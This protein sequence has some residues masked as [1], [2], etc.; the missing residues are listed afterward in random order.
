MKTII[1]PTGQCSQLYLDISKQTHVLVAGTTGSG[2]SVVTRGIL[3]ALLYRASGVSADRAELIL[4]DPKGTE[5]VEYKYAP[6]CIS[7][8]SASND[9]S[10]LGV[11]Q[12]ASDLVDRRFATMQKDPSKMDNRHYYIGS[13]VWVVIDELADLMLSPDASVVK[14]LIQHIGQLGRAARVHLLCC[15]Q[16]PIVK[17]IPTEIKV[18][19]DTILALRT[20]SAQDSRNII[21]ISGAEQF[22][23]VGKALYQ[24]PDNIG[25]TVE[26]LLYVDDSE[27]KRLVDHWRGQY[28]K[29]ELRRMS[30]NVYDGVHSPN[31][32]Y[33]GFLHKLFG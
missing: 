14:R 8:A 2:K 3:N 9:C 13:D 20:R 17:V 27:T 28:T 10:M 5:L 16:T 15:T 6:H 19:F 7:Y 25:I 18:N 22:P 4:I 1:G 11:L 12:G 33:S 30:N 23:K 32:R 31:S 26:D 21:G 24:C 29:N